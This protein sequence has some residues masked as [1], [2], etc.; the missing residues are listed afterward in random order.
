M[1]DWLSNKSIAGNLFAKDQGDTENMEN[2]ILLEYFSYLEL[3][4]EN[5]VLPAELPS[6]F[7]TIYQRRSK[8]AAYTY[9]QD[10]EE[11]TIIVSREKTLPSVGKETVCGHDIQVYDWYKSSF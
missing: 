7:H 4:G 6:D 10:D 2:K 1:I 9:N 5:L 3:D 8:R 11:F